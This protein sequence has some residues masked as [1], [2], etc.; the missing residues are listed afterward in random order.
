MEPTLIEG[1][2]G[3]NIH[4]QLLGT[5]KTTFAYMVYLRRKERSLPTVY[6]AAKK[7]S[8]KEQLYKACNCASYEDFENT[9][10]TLAN[11]G[12]KVCCCHH[13]M[14]SHLLSLMICPLQCMI[15]N[16]GRQSGDL[17][18]NQEKASTGTISM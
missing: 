7:G 4:Q 9:C 15:Q 11:E 6:I 5:G 1:Y 16:F 18:L 17:L 3:N 12:R 2:S 13:T 8:I 14:N 10:R